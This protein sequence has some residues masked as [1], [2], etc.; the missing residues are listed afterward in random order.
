MIFELVVEFLQIPRNKWEMRK[1]NHKTNKSGAALQHDSSEAWI[2]FFRLLIETLCV[3]NWLFL[4]SLVWWKEKKGSTRKISLGTRNVWI[5]RSAAQN[6]L[7]HLLLNETQKRK[8]ILRMLEK[9]R[10]FLHIS[11]RGRFFSSSSLAVCHIFRNFKFSI[12]CKIII[13]F[14]RSPIV[15]MTLSCWHQ[16]WFTVFRL[17]EGKRS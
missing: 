11:T 9:D 7:T 5:M 10:G 1:S 12:F 8:T 14:V 3:L 17:R 6:T 16:K 15:T 2:Y 13:N 4:F